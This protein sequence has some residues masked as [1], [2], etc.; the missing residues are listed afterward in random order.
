MTIRIRPIEPDD[1]SEILALV[2]E[3]WGDET[4]VVH[5]EIFHVAR[6]EGLKAIISGALVGFSHHQMSEDE[7]EIVTLASIQEGLGVGT[8]LLEALEKLARANGCKI[9]FAITT[10]DNL[11]ALGFYQRRGFRM[12]AFYA[13]QVKY[14]RKLKPAI[15]EIGLNGIPIRDEIRLEKTILA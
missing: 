13:D 14:S 4:I 6:L 15:P 7:C 5:G 10:N 1:Q 11:H 2:R 3:R 12:V 9:L 8:A